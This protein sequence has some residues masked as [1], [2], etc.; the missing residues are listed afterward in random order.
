MLPAGRPDHLKQ[1]VRHAFLERV[2]SNL[3]QR[4]QQTLVGHGLVTMGAP[5]AFRHLLDSR[6][7][8]NALGRGALALSP[9]LNHPPDS[10]NELLAYA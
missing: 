8:R 1:P 4:P 9:A 3:A 10:P 5:F 2:V 7:G 6:I